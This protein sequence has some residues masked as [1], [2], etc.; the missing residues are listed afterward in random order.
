MKGEDKFAGWEREGVERACEGRE[1]MEEARGEGTGGEG[2]EGAAEEEGRG[3]G[4]G[5]E[6][7]RGALLW[8]RMRHVRV[9]IDGRL[10]SPVSVRLGIGVLLV[11]ILTNEPTPIVFKGAGSF[12][13][14]VQR[15]EK[16]YR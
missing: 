15:S 3:R 4:R 9:D 5:G 11:P 7:E 13:F 8:I 12:F 1:A 16:A 6:E 10:G 2:G 14:T